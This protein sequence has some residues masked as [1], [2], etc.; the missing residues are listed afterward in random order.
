MKRSP[1]QNPFAMLSVTAIVAVSLWGQDEARWTEKN[2]RSSLGAE[3]T[4]STPPTTVAGR[5]TCRIGMRYSPYYRKCVLWLP[6]A[7]A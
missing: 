3:S 1:I 4:A 2:G 5:R 6:F 7:T